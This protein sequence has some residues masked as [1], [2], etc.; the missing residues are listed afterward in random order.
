MLPE[1]RILVILLGAALWPL[2]AWSFLLQKCS[3]GPIHL[4]YVIKATEV[5]SMMVSPSLV[6]RE[7]YRFP[8]FGILARAWFDGAC[9]C[10]WTQTTLHISRSRRR[11]TFGNGTCLPSI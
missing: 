3:I 2:Q 6:L 8:A 4:T 9:L 11:E 5:P 7:A 1:L 10:L